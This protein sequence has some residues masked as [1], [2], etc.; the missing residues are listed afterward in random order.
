MGSHFLRQRVYA[1]QAARI[2][3]LDRESD[4]GGRTS[5]NGGATWCVLL[6]IKTGS[7]GCA[8]F[9][10]AVGAV[11]V[12]VAGCA[13]HFPLPQERQ[14]WAYRIDA[15]IESAAMRWAPVFIV[16][17]HGRHYNRIGRPTIR[18]TETGREL[19]FVDPDHPSIY[20]MQRTFA[21]AKSTYTNE[22][23]RVHFPKVPYNL[24]PFNLTAGKNVGILVV[25]TLD[26]QKQPVLITTAGTCG[27]YKAFVPTRYLPANALPEDWIGQR[28]NVYGEDLPRMLSLDGY[29]Q[30]RLVIHLRPKVHRIMELELLEETQLASERFRPVSM[31]SYPMDLLNRLPVENGVRSFY[32]QKGVLKG[33]VKGSIKPLESLFLSLIS[34]DFF[35]GM[36]KAYTD[37]ALTQNP[38]YTS[39]KPWRRSDS[40]MWEFAR[41]LRYWGWDL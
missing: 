13:H 37:T 10:A 41:F 21:T 2:I 35:V 24:V 27:C 8:G 15:P 12:L 4:T 17:G 18:V 39:L 16:Y 9:L 29:D 36:D 7:Y 5:N 34:L 22:I 3:P 40:D 14:Q 6:V 38:F 32:H 30:P 23:Y 11:L 25:V 20:F 26:R 1:Q 28:Q 31:Q 19:A 33:H